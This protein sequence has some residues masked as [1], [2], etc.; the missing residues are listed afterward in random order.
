MFKS[1][2][3]GF[4]RFIDLLAKTEKTENMS[5]Q[6]CNGSKMY[7][8]RLGIQFH[9][10]RVKMRY[11]GFQGAYRGIWVRRRKKQMHFVLLCWKDRHGILF[12]EKQPFIQQISIQLGE[13]NFIYPCSSAKAIL[14]SKK[15]FKTIYVLYPI[16]N[17]KRIS[18]YAFQQ[19]ELTILD[20]RC[21]I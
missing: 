1:L 16:K 2:I 4:L 3:I 13:Y 15:L 20:K 9:Y 21:N 10:F 8:W 12:I 14:R 6:G 11:R 18:G 17:K 5:E 19:N 7:F